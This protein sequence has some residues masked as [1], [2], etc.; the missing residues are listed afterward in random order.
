M[1]KCTIKL[2]SKNKERFLLLNS[3]SKYRRDYFNGVAMLKQS[4]Y[5]RVRMECMINGKSKRQVSREYGIHRASVD[6]ALIH[7]KPP[8]YCRKVGI[9]YPVLRSEYREFIEEVLLLDKAVCH[10]AKRIYDRLCDEKG[11]KGSYDSVKRYVFRQ[12][13]GL[14]EGLSKLQ[15][16]VTLR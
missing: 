12:R 14:S 15:K 10:T 3:Y 2:A 4:L 5:T 1:E 16:I 6:K 8:G 11:Y 9:Y 7:V 13:E